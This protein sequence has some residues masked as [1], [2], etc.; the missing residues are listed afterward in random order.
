MATFFGTDR[1]DVVSPGYMTRGVI[2]DPAGSRPS[3]E[4][5]TVH[6]GDGRDVIDGGG[7]PDVIFGDAGFDRLFGGAGN[8]VLYGGEGADFFR[9]G[10]GADT[11]DGGE[12]D[13]AYGVDNV[14]DAVH[15]DP[16]GGDDLVFSFISYRLG[17][18]VERLGL[19]GEAAISGTGN[20]LDNLM[21]GNAAD[22]RLWGLGG[23]DD[24][25]GGEGADTLSGGAGDDTLN[26]WTGNDRIRGDS[27]ADLVY[28][29]EG[30]DR[31]S[32]GGG[33][34]TLFA[35]DGDDTVMGGRGA[36]RLY[37]GPGHDTFVF[38]AGDSIPAVR[39]LIAVEG[40]PAFEAPGS[41]AGDLID[42][43]AI[44]A[45]ASTPGDQA[46]VFGDLTGKGWLWAVAEGDRTVIFGNVDDD[47]APEFAVAIQDG[48]ELA[49][50]YTADDF[51]L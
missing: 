51:I 20:E 45:D 1:G 3:V 17:P 43:S 41:E 36:D 14:N 13:D 33:A 38:A 23:N 15:E 10:T 2:A 19:D 31:I 28:A 27:G 49:A 12:G 25:S 44:D 48:G 21:S 9:G 22:N 46:F 39:D 24:I 47:A 8:D 4:G 37:G 35:R 42:V 18:N 5:D 32:G 29:N 26:G 50:A 34:D 40:A 11:M 30:D 6:G 7:G 16:S